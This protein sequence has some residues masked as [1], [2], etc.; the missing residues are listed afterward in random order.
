MP[1]ARALQIRKT[2]F[3]WL[4]R[5]ISLA[6]YLSRRDAEEA[7]KSGQVTV[8]GQVVRQNV[9]VCDEHEVFYNDLYVPPPGVPR[10]WG[11]NKPK[12]VICTYEH[13]KD[14]MTIFQLL[15]E[16]E[17]HS[18]TDT[19]SGFDLPPHLVLVGRLPVNAEGLMLF[20]NDGDLAKRLLDP[21]N[22]IQSTYMVRVHGRLPPDNLRSIWSG[23]TVNGV[24]YGPVWVEILRRCWA[25]SWLRV[26]FVETRD[27]CLLTLFRKFGL[28]VKRYRRHAF[29]PYL[30]SEIEDGTVLQFPIHR[31]IRHLVPQRER[32]MSIVPAAGSLVDT[33]G[34]VSSIFDAPRLSAAHHLYLSDDNDEPH[35]QHQQHQGADRAA[36]GGWTY[37]IVD[38]EGGP[39]VPTDEMGGEVIDE[40]E[41]DVMS[42]G[43]GDYGERESR[44]ASVMGSDEPSAA[45]VFHVSAA[46]DSEGDPSVSAEDNRGLPGS[47][48]N[49]DAADTMRKR[50]SDVTTRGRKKKP[51]GGNGVAVEVRESVGVGL[52]LY[53]PPERRSVAQALDV[54][55]RQAGRP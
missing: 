13:K 17:E 47:R 36:A 26:R 10:L 45:E 11:I 53:V 2:S 51:P 48:R 49:A 9:E 54:L 44:A 24:D 27:R 37:E 31:A 14:I 22:R 6:G 42:A 5:R 1:V 8:D 52:P 19:G 46:G 38:G 43:D 32:R 34:D 29:G 50:E 35:H 3:E 30:G 23:V 39:A 55:T 18:K 16:M 12:N 21:N 41:N 33:Q 7:V 28:E 15:R 40:G 20:T 4:T 25:S